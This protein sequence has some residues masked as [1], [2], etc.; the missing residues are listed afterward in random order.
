M[1]EFENKSDIN[2]I[3]HDNISEIDFKEIYFIISTN[4]K[5]V[6]SIIVLSVIV[7]LIIIFT[8]TPL[9]KSYGTILVESNSSA[10]SLFSPMSSSSGLNLID[11]EVEIL[12]SK[13]TLNKTIN[14]F[15][16]NNLHGDMFLF[17]TKQ[18]EHIGL[19]KFLRKVLF[20]EKL[21][22]NKPVNINN[23]IDINNLINSFK[24]SV[25]INKRRNADVIEL[26][27]LTPDPYES[28]L[29]IN[30]LIMSYQ[31]I[32]K[33]WSNGEMI[34]M[35]TFLDTQIS[36]KEE[37]LTKIENE[38]SNFQKEEK[39]YS[40]V[41]NS[42]LLLNQLS[43]IEADYY[44]NEVELNILKERKQYIEDQL[45]EEERL[46]TKKLQNTINDRLFALKSEIAERESKLTTTNA[47]RGDDQ[48]DLVANQQQA[49][50]KLKKKLEEETRKLI[51]QGISV[52]DPIEYRQSLMDT[53][54]SINALE[55]SYISKSSELRKVIDKYDDELSTLPDKS[56]RFATL[57]RDRNILSETYAL[58][59]QKREEAKIGEASKLGKIRIVDL[60]TPELAPVKP[61]KV[62]LLFFSL[63]LGTLFSIIACLIKEYLDNSVKSISEIERFGLDIL[64]M[65]PTIGAEYKQQNNEPKIVNNRNLE[66][67]LITHEDGKSPVSEAYRT[68]RTNLIYRFSSESGQAIL[69]SSPGPGEGKTTTI[70]NLAITFANLGKK[71]LLVDTDLRKPVMHT[72]FNK[73]QSPGLTDYLMGNESNIDNLINDIDVNNL[74]IMTSGNVPPFPSELLGSDKMSNLIK[75]LKNKWDVVLFDLPPLMAVTDAYVILKSMDQFVL[76][77]RAGVTQKGALKRSISYLQMGGINTTGVVVNQIDKSKASKDE[78]FDYYQQYYGIEE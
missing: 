17:K 13:Q 7:G 67:R 78:Q 25:Q 48:G 19:G 6:L 57:E 34:H 66:R 46:L 36:I 5:L 11:N 28:S 1:S 43:L 37:E 3:G 4:L 38:L 33:E 51:S 63:V 15:I 49:I 8:S 30:R 41:G 12:K 35:K 21:Q 77:L 32:D 24:E 18:Y 9:Y 53:L 29:I 54:L 52:A 40:L 26:S 64:A 10:L 45:T 27:I 73:N 68:L 72:V 55:A 71:T 2:N 69:V 22:S 31:T 75:E 76:V 56:L 65:I 20:I 16:D 60:A 59:M 50:K 44:S 62:S 42:E 61:K 14:Y 58:M 39:I 70:A 23:P 47:L 74:D